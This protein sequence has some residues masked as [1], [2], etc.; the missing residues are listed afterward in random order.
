MS[1]SSCS[2]VN[3]T[4]CS[5]K[6]QPVEV[7]PDGQVNKKSTP[8]Q[9]WTR[10]C[11]RRCCQTGRYGTTETQSTLSTASPMERRRCQIAGRDYR[12]ILGQPLPAGSQE[13]ESTENTFCS[14]K[15]SP[16][17]VLPR[18]NRERWPLL[19]VETEVNGDSKSTNERGPSLVG[20]MGS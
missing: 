12:N 6:S 18:G 13:K 20:L 5:D 7:L 19:T 9:L 16:A 17:E 11:P 15:S 4:L 14:D 10:A 8:E 2:A 3:L 1:S